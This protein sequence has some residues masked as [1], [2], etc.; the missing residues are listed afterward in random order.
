MTSRPHS[1][2]G[3]RARNRGGANFF[4]FF[5]FVQIVGHVDAGS[6]VSI[7]PLRDEYSVRRCNL[8]GAPKSSD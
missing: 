7:F 1:R 8:L 6:L 3:D 5:A 4:P 2:R